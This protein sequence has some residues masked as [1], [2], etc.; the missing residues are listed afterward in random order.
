MSLPSALASRN[1]AHF[2]V[3]IVLAPLIPLHRAGL[4]TDLHRGD[5]R[6]LI[7]VTATSPIHIMIFPAPS[8]RTK[9][10]SS[11]VLCCSQ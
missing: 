5:A 8:D 11:A 9:P 7:R 2:P 3:G 4:E 6:R 1:R 10:V